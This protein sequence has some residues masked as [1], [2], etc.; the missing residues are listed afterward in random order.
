MLNTTTTITITTTTT[1]TTTLT[2]MENISQ[3][4][5]LLLQLILSH[6]DDNIDRV[7]FSLVCRSLFRNRDRYLFFNPNIEPVVRDDI[8]DER[9][10]YTDLQ[11]EKEAQETLE[12]EYVILFSSIKLYRP[13]HYQRQFIRCHSPMRLVYDCYS[14]T[15]SIPQCFETCVVD[16]GAIFIPNSITTLFFKSLPRDFTICY[17]LI[18]QT[19]TTLI[20]GKLCHN[21][22]IESG[23]IP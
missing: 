20:I 9:D 10:D 13:S 3:F 8:Y 7:C 14:S 2:G 1:T 5:S 15:Y 19:V 23:A 16:N 4:S 21:L 6:L 17:G 12:H 18:P 22:T 11:N